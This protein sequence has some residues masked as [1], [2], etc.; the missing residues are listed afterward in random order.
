MTVIEEIRP[1]SVVSP[2]S[3]DEI[4]AS[5]GIFLGAAVRLIWDLSPK[6]RNKYAV[7]TQALDN[8]EKA[9]QMADIMFTDVDRAW[10]SAFQQHIEWCAATGQER[11][12]IFFAYIRDSLWNKSPEDFQE[13][14]NQLIRLRGNN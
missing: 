14:I 8:L 9:D 5:L 12:A 2:T 1:R 4:T 10:K 3:S 6:T 11:K 13:A 7:V